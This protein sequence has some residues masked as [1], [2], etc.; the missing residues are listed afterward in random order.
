MKMQKHLMI[1]FHSHF[2]PVSTS[3]AANHYL[4]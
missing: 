4:S 2:P 1:G 3:V